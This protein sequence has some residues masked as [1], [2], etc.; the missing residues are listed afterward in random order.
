MLHVHIGNPKII[1]V[2]YDLNSSDVTCTSTDGP[3]T[4]VIW[5]RNG[6]LLTIDEG[7]YRQSQMIVSTENAI[8]K[9]TLHFPV[10]S[11]EDYNAI[12]EC[13]VLN[14]RGNDSSN[15]MLQGKML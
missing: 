4:T 15:I 6:K 14:S 7:T 9:T 2:G 1:E 11:I 12:Y 10:D 13:M 3:A 5:R 8:Y